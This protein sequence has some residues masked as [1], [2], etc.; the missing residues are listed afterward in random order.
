MVATSLPPKSLV[1]MKWTWPATVLALGAIR[2][3]VE[4][5]RVGPVSRPN[6]PA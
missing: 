3:Q 6:G 5:A 4:S 1:S 2:Y